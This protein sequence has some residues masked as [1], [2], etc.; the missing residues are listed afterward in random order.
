MPMAL[1]EDGKKNNN[2]VLLATKKL[3]TCSTLFVDFFAVVVA[4]LQRETF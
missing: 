3:C 2:N 4:R 1:N